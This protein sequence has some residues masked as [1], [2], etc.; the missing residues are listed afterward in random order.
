MHLGLRCISVSQ[1]H[2]G[3]TFLDPKVVGTY[4]FVTD[5]FLRYFQQRFIFA[6]KFFIGFQLLQLSRTKIQ[7]QM[8]AQKITMHCFL[9]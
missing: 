4:I 3:T 9:W 1:I 7:I 5:P 8:I 2:S 6:D